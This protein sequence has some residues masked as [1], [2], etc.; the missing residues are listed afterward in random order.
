MPD[1]TGVLGEIVAAKRIDVAARLGGTTL[2][3]LLSRAQPTTRSLADALAKPGARFVME[4]KR[5]SPSGGLIRD[6]FE[7][8]ELAEAYCE[9]DASCLS[10]LTDGPYF[11][12]SP[13]HLRTARASG[14][15]L[16]AWGAN[17]EASI[18]HGLALGLDALT[19]DD[20]PLALHLRG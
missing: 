10:V 12:G 8:A 18:R 6:P 2:D 19:T 7:P 1:P 17:H 9:G 13:E 15:G 5:A 4:V 3:D 14:L 20:P 16:G 11:Q